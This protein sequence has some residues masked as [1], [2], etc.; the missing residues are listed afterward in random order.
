MEWEPDEEDMILCSD[1][2]LMI[3][4]DEAEEAFDSMIA[5]KDDYVPLVVMVCETCAARRKSDD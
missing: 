1:C 3:F 2:D 4:L 5:Y